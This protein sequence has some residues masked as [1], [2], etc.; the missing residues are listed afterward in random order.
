MTDLQDEVRYRAWL[1]K[2]QPPFGERVISDLTS[3]TK[4]VAGMIDLKTA[5]SVD[6]TEVM[7]IR[8]ADWKACSQSVRSQLK[9]AARLYVAFRAGD[10]P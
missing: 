1:A 5:K 6:D 9:R 3:R 10:K 7:L 2:R 4:R 8:S